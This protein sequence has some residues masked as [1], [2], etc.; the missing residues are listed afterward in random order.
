MELATYLF[1]LIVFFFALMFCFVLNKRNVRAAL[2]L[3]LVPVF[4]EITDSMDRLK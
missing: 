2:G 4:F 3:P 1:A